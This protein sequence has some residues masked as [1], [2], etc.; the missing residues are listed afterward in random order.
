MFPV[1]SGIPMMRSLTG[2]WAA[3]GVIAPSATSPPATTIRKKPRIFTPPALRAFAPAFAVTVSAAQPKSKTRPIRYCK[4]H[5][6][7]AKVAVC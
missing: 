4:Q 1:E 5:S 6:C 2:C 3:A 7:R